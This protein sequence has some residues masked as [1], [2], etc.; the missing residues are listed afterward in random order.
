[1]MLALGGVGIGM[2]ASTTA[3]EINWVRSLS[4]NLCSSNINI[5]NCSAHNCYLKVNWLHMGSRLQFWHCSVDGLD[6]GVGLP[7]SL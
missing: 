4:A 6:L 5:I 2:M 3:V 7:C 1:M